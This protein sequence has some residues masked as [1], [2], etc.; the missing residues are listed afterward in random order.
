MSELLKFNRVNNEKYNTISINIEHAFLTLK[1]NYEVLKIEKTK[2][3][4]RKTVIQLNQPD[5]C[6]LIKL[7]EIEV[8]GY[9]KSEAIEPVKILYGNK[10]YPKT[11]LYNTKKT[12]ISY[13][14][15]KGIWV[16]DTNIPFIQLWLE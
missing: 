13:I 3:H 7:W 5:L 4:Y 6:D 14:K 12:R 9:L 8:N 2:W 11:L 1:E 15:L 16:N 10:I